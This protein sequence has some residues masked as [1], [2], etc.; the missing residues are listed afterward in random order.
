MKRHPWIFAIFA[1]A[2]LFSVVREW[3]VPTVC[4]RIG[5]NTIPR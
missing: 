3:S 2:L 5:V 1:V 4:P